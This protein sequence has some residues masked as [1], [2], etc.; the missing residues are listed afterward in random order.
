MAE[1]FAIASTLKILA[2]G[3]RVCI[4]HLMTSLATNPPEAL[5]QVV[6]TCD[7]MFVLG[8]LMVPNCMCESQE[9]K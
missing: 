4:P 2:V 9:V 8:D 3:M 7:K 5:I 1:I 6:T